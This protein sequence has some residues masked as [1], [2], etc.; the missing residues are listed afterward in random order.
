MWLGFGRRPHNETVV[1]VENDNTFVFVSSKPLSSFIIDA[2]Y[3]II[4]RVT[5]RE[6]E[7]VLFAED[8]RYFL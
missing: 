1:F 3:S 4:V 7:Y 2:K 6:V 5:F 8:F